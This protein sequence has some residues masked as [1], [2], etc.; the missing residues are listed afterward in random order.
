MLNRNGVAFSPSDLADGNGRETLEFLIV[1][2]VLGYIAHNIALTAD[3][4]LHFARL[5]A[6]DATAVQ[7]TKTSEELNSICNLGAVLHLQWRCPRKLWY[8]YHTMRRV[9]ADR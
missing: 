2:E 5:A 3:G 7:T 9:A 8:P 6:V 4:A 1:I